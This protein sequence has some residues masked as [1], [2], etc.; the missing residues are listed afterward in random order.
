M[1]LLRDRTGSRSDD[2]DVGFRIRSLWLQVGHDLRALVTLTDREGHYTCECGKAG[3]SF[4]GY[5]FIVAR[6]ARFHL[7]RV[8]FVD[9]TV[10]KGG[11]PQS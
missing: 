5:S 3:R 10:A 9:A 8:L 1:K 11:E 6:M 2:D 7:V 4:R